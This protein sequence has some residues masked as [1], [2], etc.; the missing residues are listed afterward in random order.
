M[1]FFKLILGLMISTSASAMTMKDITI[2]IEKTLV[3]KEIKRS[4]KPVQPL[5]EATAAY[6]I[7]RLDF[8]NLPDGSFEAQKTEVCNGE[9]KID[10]FDMRGPT[11]SFEPV[12]MGTSCIDVSNNKKLWINAMSFLSNEVLI[13]KN[14][15]IK[16]LW[17]GLWIGNEEATSVHIASSVG[18]TKDLNAKSM[19]IGIAPMLDGGPGKSYYTAVFDI[20]D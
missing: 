13:K 19:I 11:K 7:Q 17:G 4:E 15:D 10:V 12:N 9:M 1:N 14:E 8:V 18:G 6:M 5:R 20:Q 2:E 3:K 16:F